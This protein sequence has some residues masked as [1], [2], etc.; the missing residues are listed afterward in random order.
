MA[1]KRKIRWPQVIINKRPIKAD[2]RPG[3]CERHFWTLAFGIILI[4]ILTCVF[5]FSL[6]P[7]SP[8]SGSRKAGSPAGASSPPR[9]RGALFI[10]RPYYGLHSW[11]FSSQVWAARSHV[12][13]GLGYT[14]DIELWWLGTRHQ[15][16]RCHSDTAPETT[17]LPSGR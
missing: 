14:K 6:I 13:Y 12:K 11:H 4:S 10:T 1:C 8:A 2:K 9:R 7:P 15:P 3:P 5:D 17:T 16:Q